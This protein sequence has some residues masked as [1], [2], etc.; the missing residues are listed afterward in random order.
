MIAGS[1]GRG[2]WMVNLCT[3]QTGEGHGRVVWQLLQ[4][5]MCGLAF[6][7]F[8]AVGAV[9]VRSLSTTGVDAPRL[10]QGVADGAN[11]PPV[12]RRGGRGA[13]GRERF[14]NSSF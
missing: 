8:I 12:G 7:I 11:G 3:R 1:L 4:R 5:P 9:P 13:I 14:F 2:V 6:W 10:W